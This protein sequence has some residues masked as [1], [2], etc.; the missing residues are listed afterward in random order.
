M[1][2]INAPLNFELRDLDPAHPYLAERGF[3]RETIAHFGLGYCNRGLMKGRVAIPLHNPKGELVGYAGRITQDAMISDE[4]PK[5]RFPSGRVSKGVTHEFRKSLLLYNCHRV[6]TGISDL[7]IVE[8]FAGAWWLHQCGIPHVVALM[9]SSCSK[10]QAALI[11]EATL[12]RARIWIMPDG[13]EP[14]DALG[15]SFLPLVAIHRQVRW[16]K[17]GDGKQPTDIQPQALK[18]MFGV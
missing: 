6:G 9:G 18:E 14:G 13:D 1:P 3:N 16:L 12:P 7:V 10:E 11:V 5:Y 17:C 4:C 15:Y 8:G 2:V